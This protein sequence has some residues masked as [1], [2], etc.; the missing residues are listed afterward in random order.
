[1]SS[2]G[3]DRLPQPG[4]R[5]L[6]LPSAPCVPSLLC[7]TTATDLNKQCRE[8][9]RKIKHKH[10][11]LYLGPP[12]FLIKFE[13]TPSHLLWTLVAS[14]DCDLAKEV[15]RLM[16]YENTWQSKLVQPGQT[17]FAWKQ[18][19]I[20]V[21]SSYQFSHLFWQANKSQTASASCFAVGVLFGLAITVAR[22]KN[23]A[24]CNSRSAKV[25]SGI[26]LG[27]AFLALCAENL[28]ITTKGTCKPHASHQQISLPPLKQTGKQKWLG[29]DE[30]KW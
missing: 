29:Q 5:R 27:H 15:N 18:I 28:I 24:C 11:L 17:K 21:W 3:S 2:I 22:T 25:T 16:A 1:M 7:W 23:F 26:L 19:E 6:M 20:R 30:S 8:T 13:I 12:Y 4:L 10:T 9:A 14:N